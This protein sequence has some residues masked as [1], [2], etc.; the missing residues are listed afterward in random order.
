MARHYETEQQIAAIVEG[1]E[2]CST[3]K[4]AF[5]HLSHLTVATYYLC[6]S[7]PDASFKK[8]RSGLLKFLDHHGIDKAKYSD[9]I[10]RAWFEQIEI[11]RAMMAQGSTTLEVINKVLDQLGN[12]RLPILPAAKNNDTEG[13]S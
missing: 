2:T 5:T 12:C 4:E 11:V 7:T 3:G 9:P 1:F 10:T 6:N 13:H 8:M